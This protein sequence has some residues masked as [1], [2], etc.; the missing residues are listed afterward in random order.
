M[1]NKTIKKIHQYRL[2]FL[3]LISFLFLLFLG[4]NPVDMSKYYGARFSSAVGMSISIPEN[5]VNKIAK[6]LNEKEA[7]L[8][9]REIELDK[10]AKEMEKK[11]SNDVFIITFTSNEKT[12]FFYFN[13][14]ILNFYLMILFSYK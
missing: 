10:L 11:P 2:G 1:I 8:N 14:L 6:Q 12:S 9:A 7:D 5:P 3:V 4:L 13:N